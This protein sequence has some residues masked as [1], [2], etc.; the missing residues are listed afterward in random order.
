MSIHKSFKTQK[1]KLN[2]ITEQ[3]VQSN[4]YIKLLQ[5]ESEIKST[6]ATEFFK[7]AKIIYESDWIKQEF[8]KISEAVSTTKGTLLPVRIPYAFSIRLNSTEN[9]LPYIQAE[10]QIKTNP[11]HIIEGVYPFKYTAYKEVQFHI[12][13][14][15]GITYTSSCCPQPSQAYSHTGEGCPCGF[16]YPIVDFPVPV[17]SHHTHVLPVG[18]NLVGYENRLIYSIGGGYSESWWEDSGIIDFTTLVS[19]FGLE[20]A[21]QIVD[22]NYE[23]IVYSDEAPN[24]KGS[25]GTLEELPLTGNMTGDIWI[26][27]S[28]YY[29]WTKDESEGTLEDWKN[30]GISSPK[31]YEYIEQDIVVTG[32]QSK[33]FLKQKDNNYI[34]EVIG[35]VLLISPANNLTSYSNLLPTYEPIGGDIEIKLIV[36]SINPMTF[37]ER[38]FY[39]NG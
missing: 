17:G 37:S 21:K 15:H 9:F 19:K 31:A 35:D 25:V 24:F 18:A 14:W 38:Q 6:P 26:V 12:Y 33:K 4:D 11:D 3:T 32:Y 5:K 7:N 30:T 20:Q 27:W 1:K 23:N 22:D 36:Y 2:Y 16:L 8:E 10:I 29:Q 13:Q 28:T 34:L 39:T